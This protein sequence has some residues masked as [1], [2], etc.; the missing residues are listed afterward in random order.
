MKHVAYLVLSLFPAALLGCS[1]PNAISASPDSDAVDAGN[2]KVTV[3]YFHRT[4]RCY[5]CLNIEKMAHETL[6]KT[7][8][9]ELTNGTIRWQ[10]VD[11]MQNVTLA[12]QFEVDFPTLVVAVNDKGKVS[13]FRRLDDTWDL[14][15][16]PKAF[17]EML[18]G[19]VNEAV[20]KQ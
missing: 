12:Q 20:S 3:Y 14:K 1:S 19:A 9:Q 10:P 2:A 13:S 11:Y 15:N 6:Q 16:D 5:T 4:Y 18:V 8:P 7:Y 17:N